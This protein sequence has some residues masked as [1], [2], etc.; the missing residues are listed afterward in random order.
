MMVA[1][2]VTASASRCRTL[3]AS[4]PRIESVLNCA[5]LEK[6]G[7]PTPLDLFSL[8]TFRTNASIAVIQVKLGMEGVSGQGTPSVHAAA[9][10]QVAAVLV[11]RSE[12]YRHQRQD[13]E[14]NRNTG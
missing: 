8:Y 2:A 3:I 11:D 13:R 7:P 1:A 9:D 6:P 10:R 4:S 12:A 14:P 5:S